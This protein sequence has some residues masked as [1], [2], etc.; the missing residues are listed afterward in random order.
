[1]RITAVIQARMDSKRLPGKVL[2]DLNGMPTIKHIWRR[3]LKCRKV[4]QVVISWGCTCEKDETRGCLPCIEL[5][6]KAFGFMPRIWTGPEL[7]IVSRHLGAAIATQAD[8]ILRITGDCPFVDPV[9]V[10]EMAQRY[11]DMYPACDVMTNWYPKAVWPDGLDLDVQSVEV[12][13]RIAA[14]KDFPKEEYLGDMLKCGKFKWMVMP[15]IPEDLST[16]R[17]TLD[18][19]EDHKAISSILQVIGNDSWDW[20]R[21]P[22]EM[23]TRQE[24]PDYLSGYISPTL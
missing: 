18:T 7:D 19:I 21:I 3:L 1:M 22:R 12:L 4:D 15:Y 16:L 8:A 14:V 23:I 11:R 24:R 5:V 9:L 2:M 20:T 13:Q 10:D 17:L 6:T